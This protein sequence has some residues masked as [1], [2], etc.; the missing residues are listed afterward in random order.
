[1]AFTA[2]HPV[3]GRIDASRFDLGCGLDWNDVYRVRPRIVLTCPECS[4]G[5]HA[6]LSPRGLPYFA[7][8]PGRSP[9]CQLS[10]ESIEHHLLKLELATTIRAASWH[11]EL[12]V[13]AE[14]GWWRADV[15]ATSTDGT[16]RW[17]WEAQLSP[18][19]DFELLERTAKYAD[20]DIDVCWVTPRDTVPWLGVGPSI[21]VEE[22]K[23]GAAWTVADGLARFDAQQGTWIVVANTSLETFVRGVLETKVTSHFIAPRYRRINLGKGRQ[24][25]RNLLWTTDR[26]IQ[27]EK[28]HDAMRERQKAWKADKERKEQEAEQRRKAEEQAQREERERQRKIEEEA[29]RAEAAE[30]HRLWM[31][32][33]EKQRQ[34]REAERIAQK[35]RNAKPRRSGRSVSG[36]RHWHK[37]NETGSSRRPPRSGGPR[38]P[39]RNCRNCSPRSPNTP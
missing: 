28:Q 4:F 35:K 39:Q 11:A 23:G 33:W 17:A 5:V 24:A 14:N 22:P 31:I 32:E 12:E 7:H 15:M 20:A 6:K 16:R 19:T 36:K 21:R 9:E 38:S 37:P 34:Q 26:S 29:R 3:L 8:D 10:N 30:K 13:R 18:I 1:M 2:I 27:V 25:R